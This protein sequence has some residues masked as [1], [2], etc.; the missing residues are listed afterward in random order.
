MQVYAEVGY[1]E[2]LSDTELA[3]ICIT[4]DAK[5][6]GGAPPAELFRLDEVPGV[7]VR[8]TLAEGEKCQRCWKVL[9]EV[10]GE[11]GV[12]GTC[13]RCAD[14]VRQRQAGQ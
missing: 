8:V 1:R 13:I 3:E 10:G 11:A 5:L 4:S 2:L 9:P 14:A 12:P 7:G 6:D